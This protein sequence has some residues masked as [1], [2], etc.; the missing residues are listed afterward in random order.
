VHAA[1]DDFVSRRDPHF[2]SSRFPATI[3]IC[4]MLSGAKS[5]RISTKLSV[6]SLFA[7]CKIKGTGLEG[8]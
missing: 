7:R 3:S 5:F 4:F 6:T 8:S 2:S 1:L